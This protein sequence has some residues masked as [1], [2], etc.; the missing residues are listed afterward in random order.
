LRAIAHEYVR[1]EEEGQRK[2]AEWLDV[3]TGYFDLACDFLEVEQFSAP[4]ADPRWALR[5]LPRGERNLVTVLPT[6][7]RALDRWLSKR[8][9][10]GGRTWSEGT[11]RHALNALGALPLRHLRG[12][13]REKPGGGPAQQSDRR[14]F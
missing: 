5:R 7:V 12:V 1:A 14:P 4:A 2:S 13:H 8:R 10:K 11:R 3:V 6:N 9:G